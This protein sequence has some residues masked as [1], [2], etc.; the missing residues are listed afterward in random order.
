M[1]KRYSQPIANVNNLSSQHHLNS[2]TTLEQDSNINSNENRSLDNSNNNIKSN[3]EE[4]SNILSSETKIRNPK[5]SSLNIQSPKIPTK[6]T[7][8]YSKANENQVNDSD[9]TNTSFSNEFSIRKSRRKYGNI[10]STSTGENRES[11]VL[12][13]NR[14]RVKSHSINGPAAE[15]LSRNIK[16]TILNSKSL[17]PDRKSRIKSVDESLDS[18]SNDNLS[19][20]KYPFTS[21]YSWLNSRNGIGDS[22]DNSSLR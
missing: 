20:S 3:Q 6:R 18:L 7:I 12:Q 13:Y 5:D 21:S 17:K 10:M 15:E 1:N 2:T 14:D 4:H 8:Q 9:E 11:S 16:E 22:V 19:F